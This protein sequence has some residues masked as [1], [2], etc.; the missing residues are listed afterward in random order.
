MLQIDVFT[1]NTWKIN[2]ENHE[3]NFTN[4]D[5]NLKQVIYDVL[6]RE[7]KWIIDLWNITIN[8]VKSCTL[9][10]SRNLSANILGISIWKVYWFILC[11]SKEQKQDQEV[12]H[13]ERQILSECKE[14]VFN[15]VRKNWNDRLC[16]VVSL[17][18]KRYQ[19]KAEWWGP[20]RGNS[21]VRS[22]RVFL[23]MMS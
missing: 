21:H 11:Y 18:P 17:L 9:D 4:C 14:E 20:F 12:K 22:A 6:L 7:L 15:R 2:Q 1:Q 13:T 5:M 16:E 23:I 3:N 10:R 19:A 8:K